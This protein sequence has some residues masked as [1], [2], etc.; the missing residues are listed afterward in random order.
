VRVSGPADALPLV[1][2]SGSVF[3]SLILMGERE[4]TFSTPK[5]LQRLR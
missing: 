2:L 4:K 1:L 5:A 3:S